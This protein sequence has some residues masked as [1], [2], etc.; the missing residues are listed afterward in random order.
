MSRIRV[1]VVDD[2]ALARKILTEGLARD[3][4]IEVIGAARDPLA[5]QEMMRQNR[6]DVIVLD[7][8]MPRMDGITFL[9]QYMPVDPIPTV[10]VSAYTEKG[11]KLT[12]DAL[13]AGAVDVVAKPKTGVVDRLP[14]MMDDICKRVKRAAEARIQ[15]RALNG[16]LQAA[17]D[18]PPDDAPGV[19]AGKLIAIGASAGGVKALSLIIP[20]FP[21]ES[22]GIVIAQHMPAGF[23]ASFADRLNKLSA[24]EVKEAEYGDRVRPGLV[25]LAPGGDRHM[26]VRRVGSEYRIVLTEGPKV[27]GHCPSVDV[28]FFSVARHVGKNAAAAL[29]TGMGSDGAQGLKAI[30]DAG[31][32]TFAQD[33]QT[34]VVFGMPRAA[35]EIGAAQKLLPLDQIP[36]ALLKA[37]KQN[38]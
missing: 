13:A 3:P 6:P 7:I 26:Q 10:V 25:L 14:P 28:L 19:L 23:T 38:R 22:P 36:A 17:K 37:L 9:R 2:S 12:L 8:E 1:L 24:M 27:S 15:P 30:R 32:A 21:A 4:D 11:K 16:F 5:A 29:L 34:S 20:A 18:V 35:W 31:G 33:E